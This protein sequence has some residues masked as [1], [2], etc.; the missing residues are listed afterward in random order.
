MPRGLRRAA[1]CLIAVGA[2]WSLTLGGTVSA[3]TGSVSTASNAFAGAPDWTAPTVASAVVGRSSA[4]D[5]GLIA[6]G[7]SYYV[8]AN[9]GDTGNPASGIASVTANVVSITSGSTAVALTA[10]S[11]SGGGTAY[12]YRSA[13]L[14]AGASLSAGS[15]SYSI[16]STD[17]GANAGTQSFNTTV[18]NTAPSA[19]DVQSANVTGGTVGQLELG[20]TLTLTTSEAMDP[21]SILPGWNGASTNVEVRMTD[22]GGVTSDYLTFYNTNATPTQIPLGTVQLGS[23][24][25]AKNGVGNY[26]TYGATGTPTTMIR[27][28]STIT[29]VLGTPTGTASTNTASAAMTWTPSTAATDIA[30]NADTATVATQSGTAHNNF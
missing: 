12:G 10:G 7:A 22:A 26:V 5:T 2:T 11:Y 29:I 25:Y 18:D 6:Q 15:H 27:S 14:T 1:V 13:A 19:V 9:V 16:T 4:Y 23:A 20:D 21:Y 24:G 8:Y 30:G 3:Y 17:S 28:G